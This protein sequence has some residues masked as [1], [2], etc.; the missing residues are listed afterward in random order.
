MIESSHEQ[1]MVDLPPHSETLR[2]IVIME[3]DGVV[4]SFVQKRLKYAKY[5]V[6]KARGK[7]E[8]LRW[9]EQRGCRT[10]ILDIDMGKDKK[11]EDAALRELKA[12][13]R[14]IFCVILTHHDEAGLRA[15]AQK[16]GCDAFL[17][18]RS[19]RLLGD[20]DQILMA[21]DRMWLGHLTDLSLDP[22]HRPKADEM[23]RRVG[24]L[25]RGLGESDPQRE[26]FMVRYRILT[27]KDLLGR[28]TADELKELDQLNR[29]LEAIECDKVDG[30]DRAGKGRVGR[31]E[32][33]LDRLADILTELRAAS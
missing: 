31:L 21:L 7:S 22:A 19:D 2:T 27:E 17:S 9:A 14:G 32:A 13:N 11:E 33:S 20:F 1:A 8:C 6:L 29:A 24:E 16:L 10:F 15:E 12:Y 18:K 4:A 26:A 30:L 28:L 3:D 25:R 23:V 5:K